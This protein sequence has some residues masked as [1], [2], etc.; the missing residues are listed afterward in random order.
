MKLKTSLQIGALFPVVL[1]IIVSLSLFLR[2]RQVSNTLGKINDAQ[3]MIITA[4]QLNDTAYRCVFQ[5]DKSAM[6][7][8]P[9]LCDEMTK[10]MAAV[11]SGKIKVAE[12]AA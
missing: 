10:I 5:S 6:A 3:A 1:A 8:W 4:S 9:G 12:S 11:K 2:A 7:R